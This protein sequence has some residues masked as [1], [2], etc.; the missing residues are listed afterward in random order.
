MDV[1]QRAK[2]WG[3][4]I[5]EKPGTVFVSREKGSIV[6]FIHA[7]EYR[8]LDIENPIP[9]EITAIYLSPRVIG[10]G[11][12]AG[13]MVKGIDYLNDEGF[14]SVALWVLEKN[15]RA[16]EFYERFNFAADGAAKVHERL[17]L[18][19]LRYVRSS[20]AT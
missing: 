9:G 6:G 8:D 19:E 7:R 10:T 17:G 13:L 11:I 16:I 5:E 20:N 14:D 12:G 15:S 18:K 4:A 3:K 1:G 2:S